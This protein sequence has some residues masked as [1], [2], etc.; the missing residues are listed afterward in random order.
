MLHKEIVTW[1]LVNEENIPSVKG[2][3]RKAGM[4]GRYTAQK[5]QLRVSLND[6]KMFLRGITEGT[7]K[8]GKETP[9]GDTSDRNNGSAATCQDSR[10]TLSIPWEHILE[11]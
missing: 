4:P 1:K 6:S 11:L 9:G 7:W 8:E 10:A 3:D 2:E 5:D